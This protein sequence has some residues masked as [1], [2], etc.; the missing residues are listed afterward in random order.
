[1]ML[2]RGIRR[3]EAASAPSRRRPPARKRGAASDRRACRS[4]G[5]HLASLVVCSAPFPANR[6]PSRAT[7]PGEWMWA[8]G[9]RWYRWQDDHAGVPHPTRAGPARALHGG[10]RR[11]R[12]D[13]RRGTPPRG[14]FRRFWVR[15]T[16]MMRRRSG[17]NGSTTWPT[18]SGASAG[19][20]RTAAGVGGREGGRAALAVAASPARR[21]RTG[22]PVGPGGEQAQAILREHL[23]QGGRPAPTVARDRRRC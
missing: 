4:I 22:A 9:R 7:R 20:S 16:E 18:A 5:R 17:R 8:R 11:A 14:V 13:R 10:R 12:R 15:F 23:R 2:P 19:A 1:M 21:R 3:G 6:A